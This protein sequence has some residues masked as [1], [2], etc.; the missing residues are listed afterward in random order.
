MSEIETFVK[1][2]E[3]L[4]GVVDQIPDDQWDVQVPADFPTFDDGTYTL[5]QVLDY[6]AYDEAWVPDMVAGRTIDEVGSDT[7]GEPHGSELLADAPAQRF[8]DLSR[9]ALEAV[10]SLDEADL[11]ARTVHYSYGDFP[12]REA[13]WHAIVFRTGRAYDIAKAIGIDPT[14]PYDLVVDA[15][16]IIEPN[17]E[18]WRSIG[19]FGPA[20]EVPDDASLQDRMLALTGRQV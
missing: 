11:D 12:L 5:R 6:Q 1:A 8:R 19:V 17:A 7:Y 16:D 9:S 20:V 14:L 2:D 3:R 4:A 15:W 18:E 10:R 13:L